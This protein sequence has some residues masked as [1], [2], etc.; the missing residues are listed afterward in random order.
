[1]AH[2]T[3]RHSLTVTLS[4]D[5]PNVDNVVSYLYAIQGPTDVCFDIDNIDLGNVG[6]YSFTFNYGDS[7]TVESIS[8]VFSNGLPVELPVSAVEHTYYQTT[9]AASELTAVATI[10]YMSV[11]GAAPLT[12][13]HKI[14]FK[15]SPAN[16]IEKNL[17]IINTQLFTLS[18]DNTPFFN[19]ES[20]ENIIYPCAFLEIDDPVIFDDNIYL[21]T[22]PEVINLSDTYLYSTEIT[23]ENDITT[24]GL[25]ALSGS[26]FTIQGKSGNIYT[27]AFGISGHDLRYTYTQNTTSI[28]L[29]SNLDVYT[30]FETLQNT[31]TGLFA[32]NNLIGTEF[33]AITKDIAS[34]QFYQSNQ[35]PPEATLYT[36][37][38]MVSSTSSGVVNNFTA[39]DFTDQIYTYTSNAYGPSGLIGL[40]A[41]NRMK[42]D[43]DG[44]LIRAL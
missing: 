39:F 20:D 34:I 22:D 44:V 2:L 42:T 43:P 13:E 21:N 19:L 8:P 28:L 1:M 3:S 18:G 5:V 37:T 27:V 35:L 25:S 29:S 7:S 40:S 16:M 41:V 4:N 24:N 31:V 11:N 15:Q 14:V 6:I 36:N 33:S 38:T 32:Q 30:G 17:E 12:T 10:K 9:T 23:L 26:G